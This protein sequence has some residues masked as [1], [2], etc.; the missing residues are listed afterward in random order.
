VVIQ[1]EELAAIE[2]ALLEEGMELED[3]VL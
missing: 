3:V 2:G 1:E